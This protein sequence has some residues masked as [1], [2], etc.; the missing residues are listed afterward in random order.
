MSENPECEDLL[1]FT[2]CRLATNNS[3]SS[4]NRQLNMTNLPLFIFSWFFS[5][6]TKTSRRFELHAVTTYSLPGVSRRHWFEEVV[7]VHNDLI[8]GEEILQ[9]DTLLVNVH[10]ALLHP[11]ATLKDKPRLSFPRLLVLLLS[12]SRAQKL[13]FWP[14]EGTPVSILNFLN[15]YVYQF[16]NCIHTEF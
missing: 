1:I 11:P 10:H 16:R 4:I 5:W 13:I 15:W 8:Q 3:F 6:R 12:E 2:A 7:E 9:H 14:T